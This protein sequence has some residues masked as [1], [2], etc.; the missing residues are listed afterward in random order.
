[1]RVAHHHLHQI[2]RAPALVLCDTARGEALLRKTVKLRFLFTRRLLANDLLHLENK[3][4]I[5]IQL[6]NTCSCITLI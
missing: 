2:E 5:L 3:D 4:S 6:L 1:M